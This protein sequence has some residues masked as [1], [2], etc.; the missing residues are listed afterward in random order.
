MWGSRTKASAHMLLHARPILMPS[1]IARHGGSRGRWICIAWGIWLTISMIHMSGRWSN[2][3]I[4]VSD[5]NNSEEVHK[6]H[7]YKD[8]ITSL[9]YVHGRSIRHQ[10]QPHIPTRSNVATVNITCRASRSAR[11]INRLCFSLWEFLCLGPAIWYLVSN[12]QV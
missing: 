5:F 1:S 3:C 9:R 8:I 4:F 11:N 2:F 6:L 12:E 7:C 10:T